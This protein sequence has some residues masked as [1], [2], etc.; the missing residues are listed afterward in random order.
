MSSVTQSVDAMVLYYESLKTKIFM[1]ILDIT[2]QIMSFDVLSFLEYSY[3]H[4][5]MFIDG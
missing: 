5:V 2:H 4:M 1:N 3:K